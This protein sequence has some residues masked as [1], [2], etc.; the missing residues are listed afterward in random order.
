MLLEMDALEAFHSDQRLR[1]IDSCTSPGPSPSRHLYPDRREV[2]TLLVP[3]SGRRGAAA[4][5]ALA[6]G[7]RLRHAT[8]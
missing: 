7:H 2:E 8:A 6:L 5:R 1:M 4:A 3:L